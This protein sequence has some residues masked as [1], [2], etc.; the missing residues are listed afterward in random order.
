M[1]TSVRAVAYRVSDLQKAK[2]WY[3][4]ILGKG[5]VFD[6]PVA[7]IFM[8]ADAV[9]S[10]VPA[11]DSSPDNVQ[12]VIAYWGVEDIEGAQRRL[13]DA[14]AT[15]HGEII[16]T[17][18]GSRAVTVADPF[19]NV[20]GLVGKPPEPGKKSL[21]EQPSDSA[22][23]VALFRAFATSEKREEIR[24]GDNLAEYFLPQHF[25]EMLNNPAAREWIKSKAPGSYEYFLART[26]YFDGVVREALQA[27][28][29]QIV[30]L[31]AGY[32]S[33]PY[34]FR[35][36]IRDTQIFE[37]D[38]Q[39]TQQRKRHLIEQAGIPM[40][41]NLTFVAVDFSLDSLQDVLPGA[42]FDKT[43]KTLFVW[44]GV[45][46]Y[47]TSEAVDATL[48]FVRRDSPAGSDLCFDYMADAPDMSGRYGVAE[49]QAL[50]NS[51]YHAEPIQFRIEE[52]AIESFLSQ[53]GYSV[54][55]HF[56]DKDLEKRYLSLRDGSSG[57]RV[58]ACF[59]L[60][61]ASVNSESPVS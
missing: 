33:R 19:G 8:V 13:L 42:G 58:L 5:P 38:I 26:A 14:G 39:S 10:L 61:R 20:L 49:S 23:G 54:G 12:P 60:V 41:A 51:T 31:G 29:P 18:L 36:L 9:L 34:R 30:F 7:V 37:V 45:T 56:T 35:D 25:R 28:L 44:E 32:D 24:G 50:M 48:E 53:R 1:L 47:L 52:G 6:S 16:T 27:N 17:A 21:R 3:R 59:R 4:D 43:R 46:Y 40:P 15:A 22:V 11:V 2:Q 57:G 55:E